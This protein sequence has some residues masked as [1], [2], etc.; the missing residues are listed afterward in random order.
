MGDCPILEARLPKWTY[1]ILGFL[2]MA[3]N[4]NSENRRNDDGHHGRRRYNELVAIDDEICV[5]NKEFHAPD[6]SR[7]LNRA[8]GRGRLRGMIDDYKPR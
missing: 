6:Y 1:L 7:F 3:S 8:R 2:A 5:V 4:K